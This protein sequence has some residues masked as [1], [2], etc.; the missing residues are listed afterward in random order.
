MTQH[1]VHQ[2]QSGGA[3]GSRRRFV[4]EHLDVFRVAGLAGDLDAA[5]PSPML[6]PGIS[7]CLG[8]GR[9][10]VVRIAAKGCLDKNIQAHAGLSVESR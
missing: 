4:G 9:V 1:F 2:R 8:H 5:R 7:A 3:P 10:G 6:I